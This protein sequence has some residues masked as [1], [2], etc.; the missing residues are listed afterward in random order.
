MNL[1][2]LTLAGGHP[3]GSNMRAMD[4]LAELLGN[5]PGM[6]AV[7]DAVSRLVERRTEAR[8]LPPVLMR[9][10]TGT[11]KGLLARAL[12]RAGPRAS[13]PFVD[14]NCAAIPETLL[15]AEMFGVERGAF[16]DARETKPG[17]FR[18]AHRGT[19]FLDEIGLLP[20]G[21][22]VKLLSAIEE[23]RIRRLGGTRSE[24]V[25]V[26]IIAATNEDLPT[27]IRAGR[28]REDLY[29]RLSVITLSLPPL[30]ERGDDVL[31]L[32]NHFLSRACSEYDLPAK[33][34]TP[35]AR[36]ALATHAW[37]GNVRELHNVMER[38]ALLS[39]A[40]AITAGMLGLPV[41]APESAPPADHLTRDEGEVAER[42][43]LLQA[44]RET[45]WNVSRAAILLG[46]GRNT[47]RYRI[48]KFGLRPGSEAEPPRRPPP[49]SRPSPAPP[50][51]VEE[52]VAPPRA[53]VRWEHR[54]VTLLFATLTASREEIALLEASRALEA[55]IQKV[56]SFGGRIEELSQGAALAV[57][58]L[59]P[60][61][62][63]SDRAALTAIALQKLAERVREGSPDAAGI[64]LALH[65]APFLIGRV[66]DR[67][68]LEES[69]K[70]QARRELEL[71]IAQATPG[72]TVV[73]AATARFLE[74]RFDLE[75]TGVASD[76][77]GEAYRLLGREHA[78]FGRRLAR[79][80]GRREELELLGSRLES[81]TRERGQAVSIGGA[82]GM[83]K[84]RLL[85]EFRQGLADHQ[86][87]YLE[88]R[89]ASY[90]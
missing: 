43:R 16:T 50:R 33:V 51:P 29:H 65:T 41:R 52:P 8:R 20:V 14:V 7:R 28:F 6:V 83:G 18:T 21:L 66:G 36:A 26:W 85:F 86:V 87:N 17:L 79:F 32:A 55:C 42:E 38:V 58:G 69:A 15:E 45:D 64:K 27:A 57:F 59:E 23:Q 48:T 60:L 74:R 47:V 62:D 4:A 61:E 1:F 67:M 56:D 13:G 9:G 25:D 82:A 35:D 84:S 40:R 31:L 19:L 88:A 37:P 12:H 77:Q 44:L 70:V 63:A 81:A 89:C 72:T 73:S 49:E 78:G 24:P 71:L 53:T 68:G 54:R 46:V 80:V 30:R 90:W 2:Q 10:E 39:D 5:S 3:R 34:F 76:A 22:Q 75:A 11:G